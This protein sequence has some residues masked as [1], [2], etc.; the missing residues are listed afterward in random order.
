[1]ISFMSL[2]SCL[3]LFQLCAGG[4]IFSAMSGGEN[5]RFVCCWRAWNPRSQTRDLGH[6]AHAGP[7]PPLKCA[8]LRMTDFVMDF[9]VSHPFHDE[10]VKWMGHRTFQGHPAYLRG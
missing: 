6:P 2:L 3:A 4:G 9:V 5:F 10:A 7:S 8:S 1:M